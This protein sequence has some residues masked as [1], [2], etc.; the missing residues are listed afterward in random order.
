MKSVQTLLVRPDWPPNVDFTQV[1]Q[2]GVA[3]P[4][5]RISQRVSQA[6]LPNP[7]QP[8]YPPAARKAHVEGSVVLLAH[9]GVDGIV[10]ELYVENGNA[11]LVPSAI[12]AVSQWKYPPYLL[13]GKPAEVETQITVAFTLR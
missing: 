3:P 6:L 13:N 9:I 5:V 2:P 10:K 11:L 7:H 4:R 8:A 1:S 12:N